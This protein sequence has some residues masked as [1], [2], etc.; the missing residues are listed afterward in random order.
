MNH[1]PRRPPS[2]K[3]DLLR[4]SARKPVRRLVQ[5]D[6]WRAEGPG[7]VTPDDDGHVIMS[8]ETFELRNTDFPL[9]VQIQPDADRDEVIALLRKVTAYLKRD[10]FALVR[11]GTADLPP[12]EDLPADVWRAL[13]EFGAASLGADTVSLDDDPPPF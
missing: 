3:L 4:E 12:D 5:V 1:K 13:G 2:S 6:C 10:W 8:G 9:R 11:S 7:P